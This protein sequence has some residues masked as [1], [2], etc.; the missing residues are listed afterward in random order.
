MRDGV[1]EARL[2]AATTT[3]ARG[4][5]RRQRATAAPAGGGALLGDGGVVEHGHAFHAQQQRQAPRDHVV[6]DDG[7]E[8]ES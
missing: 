7:A 6:E 5:R 8:E 1:L 3:A 2:A 4:F